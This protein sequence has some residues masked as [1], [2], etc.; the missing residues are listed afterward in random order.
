VQAARTD[1]RL[2]VQIERAARE[3]RPAG[4]MKYGWSA[5]RST[6]ERPDSRSR[7]L[8]SSQPESATRP[9]RCGPSS[10]ACTSKGICPARAGTATS[11][12]VASIC[13]SW[14]FDG[15]L[16]TVASK[17]SSVPFAMWISPIGR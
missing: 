1:L 4:A 6:R 17:R 15:G 13:W 11:C 3:A 10:T 14:S 7:V 8:G 5:S 9:S 16:E 12:S 2:D